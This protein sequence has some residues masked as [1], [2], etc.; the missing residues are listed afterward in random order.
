MGS[1]GRVTVALPRARL[2]TAD[3]T[4]ARANQLP[5]FCKRID[6][7]PPSSRT[8]WAGSRARWCSRHLDA[9]KTNAHALLRMAT[10]LQSASS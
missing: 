7:L 5:L 9:V 4:A 6:T 10:G 8:S 3:G 1:F 2:D